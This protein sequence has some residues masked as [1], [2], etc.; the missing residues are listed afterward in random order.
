[1][2]T[3]GGKTTFQSTSQPGYFGAPWKHQHAAGVMI[4]VHRCPA[5]LSLPTPKFHT[6]KNVSLRTVSGKAIDTYLS[7]IAQLIALCGSLLISHYW[8]E[9]FKGT[10]RKIGLN[11]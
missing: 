3:N 7:S 1:M 10:L 9:F 11:K 8:L 5:G 4:E 2:S 6:D